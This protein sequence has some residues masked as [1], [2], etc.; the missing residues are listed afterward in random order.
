MYSP[1]DLP[2]D[3]DRG[4]PRRA[5]G[6]WNT[7]SPR[8]AACKPVLST[9]PPASEQRPL[10]ALRSPILESACSFCLKLRRSLSG[11]NLFSVLF[12]KM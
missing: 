7:L 2:L 3:P 6:W 5:R 10:P 8:R 11:V 4:I 9:K 12:R 1:P